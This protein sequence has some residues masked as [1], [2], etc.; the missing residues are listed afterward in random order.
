MVLFSGV[1]G[2][3]RFRPADVYPHCPAAR[4]GPTHARAYVLCTHD[5]YIYL[6]DMD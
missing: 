5:K 4:G 1:I 6:T 2:H 3:R